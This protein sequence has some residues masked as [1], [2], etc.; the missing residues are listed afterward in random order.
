MKKL[1]FII[2][3]TNLL[4]FA[5]SVH[6]KNLGQMVKETRKEL[7]E[8]IIG[9]NPAEV[10]KETREEFREEMKERRETLL[11]RLK[12]NLKKFRWAAR[13]TGTI[14]AKSDATLTVEATDGKIYTINITDETHLRRRFWGKSSLAEFSVG[15]E[16]SVIG[17]W[18][19][20]NQTAIDAKLIRNLSVQ[21]RWGVFFG[22]VITKNADNFVV[23]AVKRETQTVYFGEA[24]FI[25]RNQ[26]P[27]IYDDLQVG[28][29]VR[30][31][32]VW[33]RLLNQIIEVD[34]VKDFSLPPLPTKTVTPTS[35][36][37]L[38]PTPTPTP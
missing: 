15:N 3:F 36:V 28:H 35:V 18:T 13:I 1:I 21:R 30:I 2:I 23:E 20:E 12:N 7:R 29:R 34:E 33:D 38:T 11:E 22:T 26:E 5:S 16:A 6:A 19:D 10:R 9:T 27:M 25:K 37:T 24:K 32:G 4:Y 17:R 8:E 14:T 31:K